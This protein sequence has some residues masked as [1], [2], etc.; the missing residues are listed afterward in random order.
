VIDSE[1]VDWLSA[2]TVRVLGGRDGLWHGYDVVRRRPLA[3]PASVRAYGA[4]VSSRGAAASVRFG[5][6]TAAL[7]L[8]AR[9]VATAPSC[10]DDD[11]FE[12]LQFAGDTD[13]LVYQSGCPLPSADVYSVAPDGSGLERV[14][15]TP[16]HELDPA[17]SPDGTRVA[18]SRQAFAD[19][20]DGCA[21]SLWLTAPTQQLTS[22]RE[23]DAAPFDA[24]PSWSPDGRTLVFER[25]GASVEPHL[26]TVPAAGGAVRD[27]NV[28]GVHPAW[29]PALI[30]FVR[31]GAGSA[32]QTID[33]ATGAV[34]TVLAGADPGY[35]AW[36]SDGRLAYLT[37]GSGGR[38]TI[39]IV[40]S[41]T[42]IDLRRLLPPRSIA[43][44]L[45]WSPDG[46]RFAFTATD[47]NGV[48]EVYTVG[49]DGTGLVQ[50]THDLGAVVGLSDL[51]WR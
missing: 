28:A 15:T 4:I 24:R 1:P 50:V 14:A 37:S 17:L 20:C 2:R 11:P 41:A 7:R 13:A 23:T 44:G 16:T 49:V 35:L 21:Q 27:L 48:G 12:S 6:P 47:A 46:T 9:T 38:P 32:I 5:S 10:G 34:Q 30:A 43:G 40:G 18:F 42:R 3:L 31:S 51:S 8:G 39:G 26:F 29:G 19:R 36:S 33:P 45:A 22:R 25:S